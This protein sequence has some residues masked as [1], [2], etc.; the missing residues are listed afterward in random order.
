[1]DT[2]LG[3]STPSHERPQDMPL[4][5][6]CLRL[7]CPHLLLLLS[8]LLLAGLAGCGPA[9]SDN[10]PGVESRAS[11]SK[12]PLSE[13]G[14]A[15]GINPLTPV[16]QA[17]NPG[18]LASANGRG[19]VDGLVEPAWMANE[20]ASPNVALETEAQSAPL[21]AVDPLIQALNDKEVGAEEL[22][23]E[24]ESQDLDEGQENQDLDEEGEK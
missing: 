1:M 21:G 24:Q 18:S 6:P 2:F 13:Q 12:P 8:L 10:A 17:A 3:L 11:V 14:P 22:M 4:S 9:S 19:A 5:Q 23:E 20:L 16:T 15:P 7:L